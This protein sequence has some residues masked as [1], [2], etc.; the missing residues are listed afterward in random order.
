[1]FSLAYGAALEQGREFL[2]KRAAIAGLLYV[3]VT[4]L[5]TETIQIFVPERSF[6]LVDLACDMLGAGAFLAFLFF[7][8]SRGE[9]PLH[10]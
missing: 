9:K 5:L 2:R 8:S 6:D 1:M 10:R 7:K 4:G 3:F